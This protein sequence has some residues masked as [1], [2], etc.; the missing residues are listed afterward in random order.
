MNK[1]LSRALWM[2]MATS[3]G[4]SHAASTVRLPNW[5]CARPD[6]L[7][8]D[9]FQTA[10][11]VTRLP[12]NGTGGALGNSTRTVSA[13]GFGT[14]A[15]YAYVPPS[16]S[17]TQPMPLVLALHGQA[18]SPAAADTQ[19]QAVRNAWASVAATQGFIVI[20]PVGAG[21]SGGWVAPG[22]PDE[23]SDYSIFAAAI[24]D[25]EAAWNID[26]S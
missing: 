6:A 18:G 26:R 17:P 23:P 16:Y 20:A 22:T 7:F 15:V 1:R 19:A 11:A 4:F 9:G 3:V 2:L 13:A 12:S 24:A 10:A 25:A 8:I 5:V 21:A 14:Q